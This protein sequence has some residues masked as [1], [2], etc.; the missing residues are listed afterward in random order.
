MRI[1]TM[2]FLTDES[3]GPVQLAQELEQRQFSG[4]YLPE[5]THIPISRKSP[6]PAG[7]PLPRE[8]GRALDPFTTLGAAAAVTEHLTLGTGITLVAQHD[9]I[10]LAKQIA[11]LDHLSG[12]RFTFG[13]GLGWNAEEAAAHGVDWPRRRDLVRDRLA[14][15]QAL[16]APEPTA[17]DGEFTHVEASEAHPKPQALRILLGGAA[18]P[19]LFADIARFADG[20]LPVGTHGMAEDITALRAAWA[21][22]GR[23]GNPQVVPYGVQPSAGKLAYLRDQGIEEIVVMLP[24]AGAD[25]VLRALDDHAQYL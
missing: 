11:T 15:M 8:Y 12:G 10:V 4:L 17:Y 23:E 13:V 1:S 25:E 14:A 6:Y 20:W 9:P 22:A 24:S 3:I 7:G 18:G 5:H 2:T 21:E 19:K 16:W